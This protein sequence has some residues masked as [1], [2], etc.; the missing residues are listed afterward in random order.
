MLTSIRIEG[1]RGFRAFA[2]D[3]LGRVNLLVGRNNAGKTRLLEAIELLVRIDVDVAIWEQSLRRNEVIR[4]QGPGEAAG[5]VADVRHLFSGHVVSLDTVFVIEGTDTDGGPLSLRTALRPTG[6]GDERS[7]R[8]GRSRPSDYF[9][10]CS[11]PD[12]DVSHLL[13]TT[14][15]LSDP[16]R[17]N[18]EIESPHVRFV[19]AGGWNETSLVALWDEMVLTAAE[20][21]VVRAVQIVEP[22]IEKI[23]AAQDTFMLRLTDS[24][25]RVPIGAMGDGAKRILGL[26]I[27][28]AR[29]AGGTLLVDEIDTGLHYSVMR[30]VWRFLIE[31]AIRLDVQVFATSHSLDCLQA[32][33]DVC[34]EP[35]VPRDQVFVH[36]I[37]AGLDTA[38]TYSA[39]ELRVA[40]AQEM[41]IR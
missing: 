9:L 13:T 34:E 1:F 6:A 23:A 19:E 24:G 11:G 16:R 4:P 41:E 18:F 27:Q 15:G 25:E 31:A 21:D 37:E 8:A 12:G 26:A 17:P 22:R 38:T 36:R 33:A 39:D 3:G 30:P 2:K 7:T 14:G 5:R 40:V 32:L 10:I 29:S 28:L 35:G 20:K